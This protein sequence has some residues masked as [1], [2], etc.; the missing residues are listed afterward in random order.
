MD[1][2][3]LT[4]FLVTTT[5]TVL[6]AGLAARGGIPAALG[7]AVLGLLALLGLVAM[8]RIAYV[9]GRASVAPDRF[10]RGS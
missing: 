3:F 5:L 1:R 10:K 9:D 7:A 8:T 2:R 4:L 6:A